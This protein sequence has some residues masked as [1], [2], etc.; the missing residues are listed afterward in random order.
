MPSI[1]DILKKISRAKDHLKDVVSWDKGNN[2]LKYILE[3]ITET[4]KDRGVLVVD[5]VN[6]LAMLRGADTGFA[7]V[8]NA[9]MYRFHNNTTLAGTEDVL[10]NGGGVWIKITYLRGPEGAKGDK[11]EKGNTGAR[12]EKGEKGDSGDGSVGAIRRISIMGNG[13]ENHNILLTDDTVVFRMTAGSIFNPT[14]NIF[15][16]TQGVPTGK[17][18]HIINLPSPTS[19]PTGQIEGLHIYGVQNDFWVE[20]GITVNPYSVQWYYSANFF[21]TLQ[22][23][24]NDYVRIG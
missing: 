5:S 10:A 8:K 21:I 11:G 3:D 17:K 18:F 15:L 19:P 24:G 4:I 14:V 23:D 7:V 20:P 6:S 13:P 22:F 16:P 12:G 9:A 1:S 2:S